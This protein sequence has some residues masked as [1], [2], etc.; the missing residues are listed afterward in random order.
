MAAR[1]GRSKVE[2]AGQKKTEI[3]EEV[4]KVREALTKDDVTRSRRQPNR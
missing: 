3:E 1:S 4:K 2:G